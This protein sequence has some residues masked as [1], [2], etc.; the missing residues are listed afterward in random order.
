MRFV[1]SRVR[2]A[3]V[4]IDGKPQAAI[5]NGWLIF[6]SFNKDDTSKDLIRIVGKLL[7]I[8]AFGEKLETNVLDH[9]YEILL[10]PNFTLEA[11]LLSRRPNFKAA[12]DYVSAKTKFNELKTIF[13]NRIH[14]LAKFGVFGANM[15]VEAKMDGP[16]NLIYEA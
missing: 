7:E 13:Q 12:L 11:I 1:L 15:E 14:E 9:G 8:R 3:A 5:K 2:S 4:T 16:F 10:V 6:V